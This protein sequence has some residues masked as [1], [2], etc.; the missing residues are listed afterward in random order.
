MAKKDSFDIAFNLG[1]KYEIGPWYNPE[2]P[3]C[4]KGLI[5]TVENKRKCGY[6]NHPADPGGE[7]KFGVAKN[8]NTDLN[9][10]TLTLAQAK[11]IYKDR[12]WTIANCDRLPTLLAAIHFDAV[13]NCGS[14]AAT[15]QL[16][17][18]LGIKDDGS[19]GPGTLNATKQIKDVKA[20]CNL[21]L[22]QR[23]SYYNTLLIKNPIR[24][25][26]FIKGWL[27]RVD[28][29]RKFVADFKEEE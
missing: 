19:F 27:A 5:D 23:K 12:Y 9:I 22:D 14:G 8:F 17:R 28:S 1:M 13:I 15:R 3:A 4:Q 18:A 16:Q 10:K 21:V 25:R 29:L 26:N 7:T 20:F 24:N 11:K 2:D 6:V